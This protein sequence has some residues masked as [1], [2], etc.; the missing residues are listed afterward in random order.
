MEPCPW[1]VPVQEEAEPRSC[2]FVKPPLPPPTQKNQPYLVRVRLVNV[3]GNDANFKV[4]IGKYLYFASWA[5]LASHYSCFV[6]I[7]PRACLVWCPPNCSLLLRRVHGIKC[8]HLASCT[9]GLFITQ[10]QFRLLTTFNIQ[11][12]IIYMYTD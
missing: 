9:H 6:T 12:V 10:T 3:L 8:M 11:T 2:K 4:S 1:D 5:R 7:D